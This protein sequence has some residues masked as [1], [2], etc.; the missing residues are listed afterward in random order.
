M[1]QQ[2]RTCTALVEDL[3]IV[4]GSH[5]AAQKDLSGTLFWPPQ[6][7]GLYTEHTYMQA[8]YSYT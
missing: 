8:N 2:S 7:L 3:G 6:V 1:A 5:T 4:P